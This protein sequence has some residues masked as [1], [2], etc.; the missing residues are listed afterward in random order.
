MVTIQRHVVTIQIAPEIC[1][2]QAKNVS[3]HV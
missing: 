3:L 2:F 1:Q